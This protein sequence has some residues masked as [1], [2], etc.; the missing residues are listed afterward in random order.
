VLVGLLVMAMSGSA[1]SG[2]SRTAPGQYGGW[3]ASWGTAMMQ[4]DFGHGTDV[5][6][7]TV[8]LIVHTSAGGEKARI[9][10][11]NRYGSV[12][13]YVGGAHI[14]VNAY[15]DPLQASDGSAILPET[16]RKLTFNGE[17]SVTIPAGSTMV[18]DPVAVRIPPLADLAVSLYFPQHTEATTLHGGAQQTS[19]AA[20]GE[21]TGAA[22][23]AATSWQEH[24]WFF[25]SGVD[26]YAPGVLSVI[27]LGDSITDGNHSTPNANRRWPDDLAVRLQA[28]A[29]TRAAGILGVVNAGISGNRVLLDG[30]GPNA[31]ERLEDD[32][33]ERSG[34]R[35]LILF[36][37][38]NDIEAVTHRHQAYGDLNKRLEWALTQ[39]TERAHERGMV[40]I[41]ATQMPD[42]HNL[43]CASPDGEVTRQAFNDWI[44]TA[45][46]FDGMVDFDRITRDPQHPSQLLPAYDSG[47]GVHPND[48]GYS[49]M[50]DAIDL[51]LFSAPT[52]HAVSGEAH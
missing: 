5:T 38:I 18:S 3:V 19:F 8:R 34:A 30:T 44:R 21:L 14:A 33:L 50:S 31:M 35:Y 17:A 49:A 13:L 43:H 29:A 46:I 52:K 11:S 7:Q 48:V 40:V 20:N 32:V 25:L 51:S 4:A 28:N 15:T 23:L 42:C 39:I 26:V 6:G 9:W 22:S 36:H 2:P 27:A 16:D 41:G 12:P 37:G 10:L 1:Q 47:D 45:P 24:S